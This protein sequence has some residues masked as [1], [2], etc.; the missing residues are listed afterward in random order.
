M[1]QYQGEGG[2]ICWM[3]VVDSKCS[4]V[5]IGLD[6][7]LIRLGKRSELYNLRDRQSY[8]MGSKQR[9][10]GEYENGNGKTK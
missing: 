2:S 4:E 3:R 1:L 8:C 6:D 7:C 9:R 10:R 5:Q